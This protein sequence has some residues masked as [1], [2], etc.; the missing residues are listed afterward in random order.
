MTGN[1]ESGWRPA[2]GPC[3]PGPPPR[4]VIGLTLSRD[5]AA[6]DQ[7]Q[8]SSLQGLLRV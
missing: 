8:Q 5:Y 1:L 3:F 2:E 7:E 4:R 6:D